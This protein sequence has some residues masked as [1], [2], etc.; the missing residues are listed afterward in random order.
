MSV[1]Y[2]SKKEIICF[3]IN[4]NTIIGIF[5]M[6]KAKII[7]IIWSSAFTYHFSVSSILEHNENNRVW[8]YNIFSDTKHFNIK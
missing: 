1:D 8:A 5:H 7:I 2:D 6:L 3:T 4:D